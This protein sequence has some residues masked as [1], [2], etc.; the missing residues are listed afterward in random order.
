MEN[1]LSQS[2]LDRIRTSA[3]NI[4]RVLGFMDSKL[5]DTQL[6]PSAVHTIIEVGYGTVSNASELGSLLNL[7]KSSVSRM[8]KKLVSEG[9]LRVDPDSSDKRVQ[10]LGLSQS[11]KILLGQIEEFGRAQLLSALSDSSNVGLQIIEDGLSAFSGALCGD[12][13]TEQPKDAHILEGYQPCIVASITGL[14]SSF[15]SEN[16]GF[17]AVFERKVATEVSEF[18]GRIEKPINTVFSAYQGHRFLGSI[19]IDGEDLGG[20]AAHLRWFIVD[21]DA[22][23][24]GVGKR[25]MRCATAFVDSQGFCETRLWTFQGLDAARHLYE[26]SGFH[27]AEEKVGSQWGTTV[28]EQEFIRPGLSK[29]H[30]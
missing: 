14:H 8:L 15:Y 16:C 10:L 4:V 21:Q 12:A 6:P 3:R 25:L 1:H 29:H 23:G 9:L 24:L 17:G 11:G 7:E 26:I 5:A 27:L 2:R 13:P 19:S 20:N 22:H 18:L 28:T 30:A